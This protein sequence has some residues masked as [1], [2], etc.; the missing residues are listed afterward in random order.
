MKKILLSVLFM[1]IAAGGAHAQTGQKPSGKE[2]LLK[3]DENFTSK[4]RIIV[5]RMVVHGRRRSRTMEARSWIRGSEEAF[6]EYLSPAREKGTK[7]LKLGDELWT[8]S[9][10]TDRIIRIS[11]HMLRQSVMGSDLS[12]E[13][14]MEDIELYKTYDAQ[15]TG[16]ETVLGRPC[17]I[18]EL[19]AVTTDI[20]YFS[21][22]LW[23]D[24]ERYIIFKEE[25]FAKSGKLLK[26]TEV[27]DYGLID[28][29]WVAK[30]IVFK[31]VLKRGSGTEFF[32]DDVEYD[33]VIPSYVFSKA[34]LKR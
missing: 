32:V 20:A 4:N 29:R 26:T 18:V 22:K 23:V 25:R 34:V 9:P 16:E 6:T 10:S 24:K 14:M 13:D 27:K 31:D 2:L 19:S 28:G 12:Y 17:W 30:H 33:A 15:V 3:I 1:L 7:M 8:Y 21:R 5:S 11:G